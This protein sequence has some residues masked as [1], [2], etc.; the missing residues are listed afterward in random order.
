MFVV[1][2]VV[3]VAV[4]PSSSSV[5]SSLAAAAAAWTGSEGEG[6]A[7]ATECGGEVE[8][9]FV[10]EVSEAATDSGTDAKGISSRLVAVVKTSSAKSAELPPTFGVRAD[11]ALPP[12]DEG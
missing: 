12:P 1:V 10:V 6:S 8:L 3:V 11:V 2:V 9:V 4:T 5:V 7:L